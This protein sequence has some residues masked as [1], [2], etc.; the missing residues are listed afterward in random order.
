MNDKENVVYTHAY[1][2][3]PPNPPHGVLFSLKR[4]LKSRHL[5]ENDGTGDHVK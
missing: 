5:Q 4:R 2:H 1:T 3:L